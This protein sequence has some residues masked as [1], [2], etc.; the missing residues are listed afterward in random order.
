M[1]VPYLVF[2][3]WEF[4]NPLRNV[5]LQHWFEILTFGQKCETF[6][7]NKSWHNFLN[8]IEGGDFDFLN[9]EAHVLTWSVVF[10]VWRII[11]GLKFKINEIIFRV[12]YF[13]VPKIHFQSEISIACHG[14]CH[15]L[16]INFFIAKGQLIIWVFE[17]V[18]VIILRSEKIAWQED[19]HSKS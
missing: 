2:L 12:W 7:E 14:Q 18:V 6:I 16:N 10:G 17:K 4:E 19:P 1:Y 9:K 11:W 15:I 13:Y 8:W 5:W 3:P